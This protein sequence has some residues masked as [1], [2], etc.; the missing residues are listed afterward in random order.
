MSMRDY[1]V[2]DYGLLLDDTAMEILCQKVC[3]DYDPRDYCV[4][5]YAFN[6]EVVDALDIEYIS[7]FTGEGFRIED[8]GATSFI[9]SAIFNDD[10]VYYLG[11]RREIKLFGTS[12]NSAEEIIDEFKDAIGKYLPSDF[13]YRGNLRHFI[14]T[15]YG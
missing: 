15:Y 3:D 2:D 4:D 10:V 11:I 9:D 5:K 7:E 14:G 12:Y 6:E 1:G 8:D 13:D